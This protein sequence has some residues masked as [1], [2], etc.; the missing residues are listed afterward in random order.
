MSNW[1]NNRCDNDIWYGDSFASRE[2]A[3]ADGVRQYNDA[4]NNIGTELFD[5]DYPESPSGIFHVGESMPFIPTI[6]AVQIIEHL[7]EDADYQ[8]GEVAEDFL[9]WNYITDEQVADLQDNLQRE[10]DAWLKRHKL[11]PGFYQI[12][13]IEKIDA[14]DYI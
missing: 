4:L 1:Y 10:L 8:C 3:I 2:E 9:D 5:D 6:D 14:K 12:I 7:Q 13:N 11:T